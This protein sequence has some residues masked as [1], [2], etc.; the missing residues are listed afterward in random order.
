[1][2]NNI[3][4]ISKLLTNSVRD[5]YNYRYDVGSTSSIINGGYDMFDNGNIVRNFFIYFSRYIPMDS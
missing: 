3:E 2:M 5:W 4:N 1:M